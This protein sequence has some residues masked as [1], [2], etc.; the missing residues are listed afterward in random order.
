MLYGIYVLGTLQSEVNKIGLPRSE[1]NIYG[2]ANYP[3]IHRDNI[4]SAGA[5]WVSQ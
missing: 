2:A 5:T 1:G 3:V 4:I